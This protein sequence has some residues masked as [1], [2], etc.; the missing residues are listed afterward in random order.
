MIGNFEYDWNFNDIKILME[1]LC[2]WKLNGAQFAK[3]HNEH[4]IVAVV[5][6]NFYLSR[7][8]TLMWL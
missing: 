1:I 6:S 7:N 2:D 3:L 4:I 5:M 8:A